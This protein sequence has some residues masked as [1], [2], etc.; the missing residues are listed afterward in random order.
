MRRQAVVNA[1][2]TFRLRLEGPDGFT[3][4]DYCYPKGIEDYVFREGRLRLPDR[5]VFIQADRRGRDR[6]D[7]PDYSVKITARLCFSR[8]FQMQEYYHNSSWLENGGSPEKAAR[9]ALTSALDA[10]IKSQDKYTKKRIRHQMA[11]RAG[12]PGFGDQLLLHADLLR[13]PDEKAI[14]NRF[15]Q[16]AMTAFFQGASH[17]V[18]YREQGRGRQDRRA[19]AHQQAFARER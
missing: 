16:Q 19:G 11:G 1:N 17:D 18:P 13:E 10:Y 3:E 8:T 6:D 15:I 12:L 5:A 4:E 2:V 14:N 9:S 7:L